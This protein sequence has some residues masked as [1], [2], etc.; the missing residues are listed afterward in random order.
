MI[1]IKLASTDGKNYQVTSPQGFMKLDEAGQNT[2][3]AK[4]DQ[5]S[6]FFA[7]DWNITRGL[8][9]DWG[10]RYENIRNHGWNAITVPINTADSPTFGGLDNNPL[11]LYD[12]FGGTQATP[13]NYSKTAKYLAYSAGLNY[14]ISNTQAV[15]VRIS[16]GGKSADLNTITSLLNSQFNVDNTKEK[17]LQQRVQQYE[18]AYKYSGERL[19]LFFTPFYSK[20]SNVANIIYFRNVDNTAYAPPVQFNTFVSKGVEVEADVN[21]VAGFSVKATA[22]IQQSNATVYTTWIANTNGP[23]D[24]KLLDFSGNKTGGVPPVMF[25]IAPRYSTDKFFAVLSYNYLAPRPANTPNGWEM[26]GFNNV[27]F[28]AGYTFN[29][30]FSLQF[31]V[32]NVLNQFGIMEWLGSGGFPTSLNRDRITPEY[33]AA[34][35]NDSFSAL[36]NMPRAYFL[37]AAYKF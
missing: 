33:V 7:H 11:T 12:N 18:I 10:L 35:P 20:L 24:D 22:L 1:D 29:K 13:I 23:A 32:N 34:N 37:T 25:N 8:S 15:Y 28:S 26:K 31:N 21:I 19:K 2:A 14:K 30:H 16:D 4:Q 36:R 9:L 5:Y 3:L 27:D 17:D 6:L